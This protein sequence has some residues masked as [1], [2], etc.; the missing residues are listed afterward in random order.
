MK[1][2]TL[3]SVGALLCL[4][5]SSTAQPPPAPRPLTVGDTLPDIMLEN[6][7]YHPQQKAALS[8]FKAPLI[9][10]DFWSSWC[11]ACIRLFPHMDSLQSKFGKDIRILLVN[12]RSKASG[13]DAQKITGIFDGLKKRT[14]ITISLPV[15]YDTPELDVYFPHKYLPHEVWL[16]SNGVVLA[17]TG[18]EE[19]TAGNIQ[20][21]LKGETLDLHYKYDLTDFDTAVPLYVNGNGGSGDYFLGR[22]LFTGY[23]EGLRNRIG[24]KNTD[25]T[26]RFYSFN[27]PLLALCHRA[28]PEEMKL[29]ANRQILDL[30]EPGLLSRDGNG[31]SVYQR[32]FCYDLTIPRTTEEQL[33]AYLRED[34]KR[35]FNVRISSI[36]Q[37]MEC[38]VLRAGKDA[39]RSYSKGG[40]ASWDIDES[41]VNKFMRN[42][43]I[44]AAIQLLNNFLSIPLIDE[45]GLNK[46]I[47]L[48]LPQNL[49]DEAAL[50]Q[51]LRDAGFTLQKK[52]KLLPVTLITD[53]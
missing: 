29:P 36:N 10:L 35:V 26:S 23:I 22:S 45:T 21:V 13:D 9:I 37:K 16:D 6:I 7:L 5:F 20:A 48:R 40:S 8:S 11:G 33:W 52:K 30:K 38:W 42:Q 41:S 14:G 1:K 46:N 28:Y 50:L 2:T 18:S 53:K 25:S 49:K 44:T 4:Y 51:C 19:V 31:L 39:T 32:L 27:Q 47:D 12:T 43:S 24:M 15:V 34:L 17:I 3:T